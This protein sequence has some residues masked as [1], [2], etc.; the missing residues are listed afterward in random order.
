MSLDSIVDRA[1]VPSRLIDATAEQVFAAFADPARLAR[2]WGP[3]GFR[4]SF[5]CFDLPPGG[6]WHFVMHGPDGTDYPDV[7][8]F[9]ALPPPGPV[10]I[11]HVSET[12]HSILTI[13]FQAQGAKPLVGWQ[14]VFEAAQQKAHIAQ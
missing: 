10:V 13:R 6:A 3:D 7:C 9:Q 8:V 1:F 14:Q 12:R 5:E 4:S 2:W 11:E